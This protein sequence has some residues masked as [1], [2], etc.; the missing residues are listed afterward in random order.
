M[1][2]V[3]VVVVVVIGRLAGFLERILKEA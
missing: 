3:M 1:I 2:V